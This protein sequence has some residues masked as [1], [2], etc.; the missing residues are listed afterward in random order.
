MQQNFTG[1]RMIGVHYRG[2]D[3]I[4]EAPRVDYK[5][6]LRKI[7]RYISE[8]SLHDYK[9]FVA[10]DEQAFIDYLISIYGDLVCYNKAALCATIDN[11]T[12]IHFRN[13]EHFKR[14]E[15]ALIDALLLSKVDFLIRTC[16]NLSKFS[17]FL[18]PDLEYVDLN[19]RW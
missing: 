5:D 4:S 12:P 16:S 8:N 10:T 1:K 11:L 19:D 6:V 13:R 3:K 14:G 15:E 17:I 2:T 7:M 9:I 18:S